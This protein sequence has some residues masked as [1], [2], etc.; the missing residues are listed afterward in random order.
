M[1]DV[2]VQK[3]ATVGKSGLS[4]TLYQAYSGPFPDPDMMASGAKLRHLA[5]EF[6][7]LPFMQHTFSKLH[8]VPALH[9]LMHLQSLQVSPQMASEIE[10]GTRQQSKCPAWAQLRQPWL[11]ASRFQEACSSWEGS[12]DPESAAKAL[13]VQMIRGSKKQ[14]AAMKRGLLM[15]S[16][17]LASYAEVMRVNVLPAGFV[18][19]PEAPHL[20]AS[21]DGR[22]Y[23]PS[24]SPPFGLVE[25][26]STTKHD[27]SQV[28]HLKRENGSVSVRRSHRY[29][30]QVQGQLA[31]TSLEWC[32][33]VTDTQISLSVERIWRDDSFIIKM[34]DKLDLFYYNTYMNV[35]LES[36]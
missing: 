29:Y 26:K 31:V 7:G 30:W 10:K 11:T 17:V 6:P 22:V 2:V 25:V 18:I 35:Y 32:D 19:H 8:F 34:K 4:S 27:A 16:E 20:R 23:D 5:P 9:Q 36:H 1:N 21:P 12:V 24:E 33:F 15:E 28:A 14:T 13:A 3:P